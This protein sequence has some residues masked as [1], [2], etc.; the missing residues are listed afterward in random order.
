MSPSVP[1]MEGIYATGGILLSGCTV[2]GV[3]VPCIYSHARW[4]TVGDSNLLLWPLS[5]ER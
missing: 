5:V 4:V 2:G 1:E 3:Y